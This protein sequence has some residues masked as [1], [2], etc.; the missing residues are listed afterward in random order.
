MRHQV[1]QERVRLVELHQAINT[2]CRQEQVQDPP[3]Q[4]PVRQ[5]CYHQQ[6]PQLEQ[7]VPLMNEARPRPLLALGAIDNKCPL[8]HDM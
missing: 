2:L 1:A 3:Q 8:A 4:Q 5:V 7:Q 6:L